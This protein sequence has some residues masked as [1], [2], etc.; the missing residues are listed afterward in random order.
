M[1]VNVTLEL[2]K[3][4]EVVEVAATAGA[5]LQTLN[6]TMGQTITNEGMMDLPIINRDAAGFLLSSAPRSRRPSGSGMQDNITSG[7]VAGN[8]SRSEYLS[9]GWRQQYQ[10]F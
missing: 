7:Q 6:A 3:L 8:M 5:E 9:T 2:G 1:T 4:T 10:R